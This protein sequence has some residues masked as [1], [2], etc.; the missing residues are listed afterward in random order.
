MPKRIAKELV[1]TL[2]TALY[3]LYF[4]VF[5]Y[6]VFLSNFDKKLQLSAVGTSNTAD[7]ARFL[8]I[9]RKLDDK[10]CLC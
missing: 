10:L 7:F 8:S 9:P 1:Q 6:V 5:L 4:L 3:K 2:Q